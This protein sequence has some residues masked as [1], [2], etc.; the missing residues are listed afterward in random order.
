M[1]T[2][3]A[4]TPLEGRRRRHVERALTDVEAALG[5]LDALSPP[6]PS[7]AG[8]AAGL[9]AFYHQVPLGHLGAGLRTGN[10]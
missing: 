1:L 7:P 3:H 5:A 4:P 9:A 2:P 6:V 10:I 8:F